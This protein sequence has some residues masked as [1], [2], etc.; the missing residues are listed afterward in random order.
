MVL[1][2]AASASAQLTHLR[3]DGTGQAWDVDR[4]L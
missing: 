2:P 3:Q 1:T 4:T